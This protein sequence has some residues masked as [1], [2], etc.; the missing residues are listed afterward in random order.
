MLQSLLIP[1]I[2]LRHHTLCGVDSVHLQISLI[3]TC[4]QLKQCFYM[5]WINRCRRALR[6]RLRR[7]PCCDRARIWWTG[8][9][10]EFHGSFRASAP[11]VSSSC[12]PD[13]RN[14]QWQRQANRRYQTPT[15][16]RCCPLVNSVREYVFYVFFGFQKTWLFTFY[17]VVARARFLERCWWVGFNRHLRCSWV[18]FSTGNN[19]VPKMTINDT[20][21]LFLQIA[22]S[23]LVISNH[24]SF[25]ALFEKIASVYFLWK[26]YL[27]FCVGNGQ[28]RELALCQLYRHTF[29]P[30]RH[31][32]ISSIPGHVQTWRHFSVAYVSS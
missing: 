9:A 25:R 4:R 30:F 15:P 26:I 7:L 1:A 22:L 3:G 32:F 17:W 11:A 5:W 10:V 8:D 13:A 29:V 23:I 31:Y 2:W 6:R 21:N 24:N 12:E 14:Y 27:Y 20:I 18:I 16:V 28:P 19:S